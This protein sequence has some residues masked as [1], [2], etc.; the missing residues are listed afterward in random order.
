MLQRMRDA[1]TAA[2]DSGAWGRETVR[3]RIPDV[4]L[5]PRPSSSGTRA[6]QGDRRGSAVRDVGGVRPGGGS[7]T[8]T[9]DGSFSWK[10]AKVS[11]GQRARGTRKLMASSARSP[12]SATTSRARRVEGARRRRGDQRSTCS[13][14][15]R[16]AGAKHRRRHCLSG[17]VRPGEMVTAEITQSADYDTRRRGAARRRR[18][19]RSGPAETRRRVSLR[20]TA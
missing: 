11:K 3:K 6:R 5:F 1:A 8:P 17:A 2:R 10:D 14:P 19:A 18:R 7:A 16:G 15:P 9:R 4:K 13:G 20:V 12:A